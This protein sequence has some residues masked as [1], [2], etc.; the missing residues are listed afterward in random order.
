MK[1]VNNE[2][3]NT[4]VEICKQSLKSGF[5]KRNMVFSTMD[6]VQTSR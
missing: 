5:E 2:N 6:L 1:A 4:E 3:T